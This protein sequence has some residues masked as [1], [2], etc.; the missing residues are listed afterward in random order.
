MSVKEMVHLLAL[1]TLCRIGNIS[2]PEEAT[3]TISRVYHTLDTIED[4]M[5]MEEAAAA[6]AEKQAVTADEGYYFLNKACWD[7]MDLEDL[8]TRYKDMPAECLLRVL[9]E[10]CAKKAGSQTT[11]EQK[12]WMRASKMLGVIGAKLDR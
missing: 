8:Q 5:D 1:E 6:A 12:T 4:K 3:T 7:D 10:E 9:T 11:E 2:T